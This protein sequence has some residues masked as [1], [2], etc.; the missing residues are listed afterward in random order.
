MS[1]KMTIIISAIISNIALI[2]LIVLYFQRREEK[3]KTSNLNYLKAITSLNNSHLH[4]ASN[5]FQLI[6]KSL[7]K[8]PDRKAFNFAKGAAH[9]FRDLFEELNKIQE[10]FSSKNFKNSQEAQLDLLYHKESVDLKDILELELFQLS[11]VSRLDLIDYTHSEHALTNGNFNLL[12]KAILNLI[13]NA[14][15]HTNAKIKLELHDTGHCWEIKVSSLGKAIPEALAKQLNKDTGLENH[16]GHGLSSLVD[17]IQYHNASI[18]VDTLAGEGS[19]IRLYFEKL[20]EMKSQLF[21]EPTKAEKKSHGL[22]LLPAA[23]FTLILMLMISSGILIFNFNKKRA[24]SYYQK[25]LDLSKSFTREAKNK[26]KIDFCS[27]ALSEIKNQ[28]QSNESKQLIE[29]KKSNAKLAD[30]KNNFL[31]NFSGRNYNQVALMLYNFTSY[32]AFLNFEGLLKEEAFKLEPLYPG[33]VNLNYL[34]AEYINEQRPFKSLYF[35]LKGTWSL[36]ENKFYTNPELYFINQVSSKH[37]SIEDLSSILATLINLQIQEPLHTEERLPKA[38]LVK[39]AA[40]IKKIKKA[41]KVFQEKESIKPKSF[42]EIE[43][44]NALI[45][46]QDKEMGLDFSL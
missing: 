19:C 46:E 2:G 30:L 23:I 29:L 11:A 33:S 31:E 6:K 34:S 37:N 14:L 13:E 32:H 44:L 20:T 5:F 4:D 42:D 10:R 3:R 18:K 21:Q 36:I 25:R 41:E 39:K 45:E 43:K 8:N 27:K 9:H 26:V 16:S 12:S 38:Q 7:E 40:P 15:Q 24:Q 17:I 1:Q 35:S 28:V 22:N